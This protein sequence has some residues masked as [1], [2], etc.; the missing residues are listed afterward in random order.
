MQHIIGLTEMKPRIPSWLLT[1]HDD[2]ASPGIP[3]LLLSDLHW[4]FEQLTQ[5]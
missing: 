2:P 4:G 3:T 1:Q 5:T